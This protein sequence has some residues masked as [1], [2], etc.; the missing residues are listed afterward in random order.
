MTSPVIRSACKAVINGMVPLVNKLIKGTFKYSHRAASN[1]VWNE[2]LFVIHLLSQISE[3]NA[4]KSLRSGSRGEVT[5]IGIRIRIEYLF[6]WWLYRM[7]TYKVHDLSVDQQE[8]SVANV[9]NGD[10]DTFQV[11]WAP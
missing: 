5:V 11:D 9:D 7:T 4:S 10:G 8:V 2:P 1:R 3:S 6:Y